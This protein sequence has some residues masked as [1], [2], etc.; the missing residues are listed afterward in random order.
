M[1]YLEFNKKVRVINILKIEK[2]KRTMFMK[3]YFKKI[4]LRS[5]YSNLKLKP[6][7]RMYAIF[8]LSLFPRFSNI[9]Q[10]N[11]RCFRTGRSNMPFRFSLLARMQ[12]RIFAKYGLLPH[13]SNAV[14]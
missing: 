7:Q 3:W 10:Y 2:L 13:I 12:I 8:R 14:I 4:F 11:T 9:T 5:V 1:E 6:K